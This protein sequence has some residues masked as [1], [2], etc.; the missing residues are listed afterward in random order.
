MLVDAEVKL[1]VS[2]TYGLIEV[3]AS[4]GINSYYLNTLLLSD[5]RFLM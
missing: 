2:Y 5:T 3:E 1:N 4:G